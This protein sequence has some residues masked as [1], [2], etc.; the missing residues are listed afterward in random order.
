MKKRQI[1]LTDLQMT[2]N[3]KSL[4]LL[5]KILQIYFCFQENILITQ[6]INSAITGVDEMD[7]KSFV[8]VYLDPVDTCINE[9][10]CF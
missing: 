1:C 9:F 2:N 5:N 4:V 10:H 8:I 6:R 7:G 3:Q